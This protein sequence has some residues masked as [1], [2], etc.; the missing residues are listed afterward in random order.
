S[1]GF[2]HRPSMTFLGLFAHSFGRL[3]NLPVPFWL[4]AYGAS[5]ALA[6][7]FVVVAYFVSAP[8]AARAPRTRELTLPPWRWLRRSLRAISVAGLVL[9]IATGLFGAANA[10][11]NFN[12]TPFWLVFVL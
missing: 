1:K 6:L 11:I 7:S 10:Y 8:A 9:C 3:Y 5:A 4:Y 12:V 2:P